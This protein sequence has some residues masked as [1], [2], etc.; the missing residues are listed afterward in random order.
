MPNRMSELNKQ[1]RRGVNQ[2]EQDVTELI[3]I[4]I[5]NRVLKRICIAAAAIGAFISLI[6]LVAY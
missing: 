1:I 2:I 5:R 6:G 4:R 3:G